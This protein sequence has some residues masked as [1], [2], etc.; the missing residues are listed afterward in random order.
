MSSPHPF[1]SLPPY[2]R[3]ISDLTRKVYLLARPHGRKKLALVTSIFP[4]LA[5][6]ADP[7]H[8]FV[9]PSKNSCYSAG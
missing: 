8:I 9:P 2:L 1:K 4:F 5:L 6:A 3:S 7:G